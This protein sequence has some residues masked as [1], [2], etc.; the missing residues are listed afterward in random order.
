MS[1]V[2]EQAGD[3]ERSISQV[4]CD[5]DEAKAAFHLENAHNQV[6]MRAL[7]NIAV[8]WTNIVWS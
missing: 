2:D 6:V 1:S 3:L 8:G 7:E 5:R 4:S